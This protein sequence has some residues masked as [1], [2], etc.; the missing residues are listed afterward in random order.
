MRSIK[1]FLLSMT[2]IVFLL[3]V[4]LASVVINEVEQDPAGEEDVFKAAAPAWVELYNNDDKDINI[5]G[6][7]INNSEGLSVTFPKGLIIKGIDYYSFDVQPKW[8]AHSGVILVLRDAAGREIDRTP[9]LSDNEDNEGAW[10]RD[11]D[12]RDTNSSEDWK[13]LASSRGF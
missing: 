12:G 1:M 2:S 6:W 7:S 11:P 3:G 8:L 5:G 10:T 9:V 13:F 4:S